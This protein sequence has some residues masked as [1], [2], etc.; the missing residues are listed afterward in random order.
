MVR[1]FLARA[2]GLAELASGWPDPATPTVGSPT[3]PSRPRSICG[4]ACSPRTTG[5][6]RPLPSRG[7]RVPGPASPNG[8]LAR[9]RCSL[10]ASLLAVALPSRRSWRC[11]RHRRRPLAV[12]SP[13]GVVALI[14]CGGSSGGGSPPSTPSPSPSPDG[15]RI[16]RGLLGTVAETI[17]V[18]RIQ[19]IRMVEPLLWRPLGWCRLEVDVAGSP[20]P[21]PPGGRR[22]GAQGPAAGAA[23]GE[24]RR[25]LGGSLCRPP[26]AGPRWPARRAGPGWKAPLSYHFLAAGHDAMPPRRGHRPAPQGDHLGAAGQGAER[27]AGPGPAAAPAR[28][29]HRA[30]RRGGQAG[31]GRIQGPAA[32]AGQ[33]RWSATWPRSAAAPAGRLAGGRASGARRWR[34]RA[35][36]ARAR[37]AAVARVPRRSPGSDGLPLGGQGTPV[38]AAQSAA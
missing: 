24:A 34:P 19:A 36:P 4:R 38:N 21:R 6:T 17:P 23:T 9:R 32:G 8:R 27:P 35:A 20:G 3:L 25:L 13:A 15:I 37:P 1:P 5:W 12:G 33:V 11:W 14:I 31:P 10:P 28:A 16:R 26:R 29:G 22:A 30:P 18:P 2:L 7:E